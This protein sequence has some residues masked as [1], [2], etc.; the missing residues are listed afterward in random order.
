ML[1]QLYTPKP[2]PITF[3]MLTFIILYPFYYLTNVTST[4]ATTPTTSSLTLVV[5]SPLDATDTNPGDGVCRTT[6][7][8]SPCTLRAAIQESN[9]HPGHDTIILN[10]V[11]Y[12]LTLTGPNENRALTGDLDIYD[13]LTINGT[14][15]EQTIINAQGLDRIF[16]IFL[17]GQAPHN[18]TNDPSPNQLQKL[19]VNINN[20]T[21]SGGVSGS[22]GT[23]LINH[24]GHLT[25]NQTIITN[26]HE[27]NSASI[28]AADAPLTITHTIIENNSANLMTGYAL[29]TNGTTNLHRTIIRNNNA[30]AIRSFN[31]LTITQSSLTNNYRGLIN[32]ASAH[33]AQS[34]IGKN[35]NDGIFNLNQ[36]NI[37][38]STISQNDGVG[39]FNANPD[40]QIDITSSTIAYNKN[41]GIYA[42][43]GHI[44]LTNTLLAHN[45]TNCEVNHNLTSHGHNLSHDTTCPLY[46][47]GDQPATDPQLATL[48]NNGGPTETNALLTGS[49][50]INLGFCAG[51]QQ[52][53]QR[54]ISRPLG[55]ACDIGAY[56]YNGAFF[57]NARDDNYLLTQNQPFTPPD[58]ILTNDNY[59][60]SIPF[61]ITVLT[62]THVGTLDLAA[63]GLFTYTPPLNFVG[64]TSFVYQLRGP[65]HQD[66]ATVTLTIEPPQCWTSLNAQTTYRASADAT[67]LQATINAAPPNTIIYLAG[68]C[69][70]TRHDTNYY[71]TTTI[72]KSIT[73]Q[74]GYTHTNWSNHN[75]TL[76]TTTLSAAGRGRVLHIAPNHNV[77]LNHLTLTNGFAPLG[78]PGAAIYN[79]GHLTLNQIH[80]HNNTATAPGA[81]IYATNGS[82]TINNSRISYN[83]SDIDSQ[84]ILYITTPW[85][86][87][88]SHLEQNQGGTLL[89][90]N[91]PAT[92]LN[93]QFIANGQFVNQSQLPLQLRLTNFTQTSLHNEGHL[94][95]QKL[96]LTQNEI[97]AILNSG[98]L[99]LTHSLIYNNPGGILNN[100]QLRLE[101]STIS[102]NSNYGLFQAATGQTK[103]QNVTLAA[104]RINIDQDQTSTNPLQIILLNTLIANPTPNGQNCYVQ[105]LASLGHNLTTDDT[106]P[107]SAPSD[108]TNTPLTLGP[109]QDNGGNTLTHALA[110]H[111]PAIGTAL[112]LNT[113]T[114]T[115]QRGTR[116]PQGNLCDIGAFEYVGT[117]FIN[118]SDDAFLAP[119][120][121]TFTLPPPGLWL[122]KPHY[123]DNPQLTIHQPPNS[124]NLNLNHDGSFTYTPTNNPP[125][126]ISF[127]YEINTTPITTATVTL[128]LQPVQ[129][130][131][132]PDDGQTIFASPDHNALYQALNQNPNATIKVAG[133][134]RGTTYHLLAPQTI[135]PTPHLTIQGGYTLTNWLAPQTDRFPT[136]LDA[137]DN[138]RLLT[139][140]DDTSATL[141]HLT[142]R[143]GRP[144]DTFGAAIYAHNAQL[145]LDHV[146]IEDNTANQTYNASLHLENSQ[147]HIN[148][149]RLQHNQGSGLITINNNL[150]LTRTRIT[151]HTGVGLIQLPAS[152]DTAAVFLHNVHI[153]HN[154]IDGINNQHIITATHI[155]LAHNGGVG[156]RNTTGNS[157]LNLYRAN[158]HHNQNGGLNNRDGHID[159]YH[160]AIHSNGGNG[161][162]HCRTTADHSQMN[163]INSTI[164]QHNQNIGV[165]VCPNQN[166]LTLNLY[167][168]TIAHNNGGGLYAND[169]THLYN[170]LIANNQN[171]DC[172]ATQAPTSHGHNLDS[173]DT[174]HLGHPTDL[175]ATNPLLNTLDDNQDPAN[176]NDPT[177]TH[178][179]LPGSPAINHVPFG[180][181]GCLDTI[182]TDQRGAS[183][184]SGGACDI[185]AYE[186]APVLTAHN[187][188]VAEE[189][190]PVIFHIPVNLLGRFTTPQTITYTTSSGT[191][192]PHLDYEPITGTLHFPANSDNHTLTIPLTILPDAIPESRETLYINLHA[193][194][195]A[196]LLTP[197]LRLTIIDPTTMPHHL[198]LPIIIKQ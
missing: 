185:G 179:L 37:D 81:A 17:A 139:L 78:H 88:D 80:L 146:I 52:V 164:S 188:M 23:A 144:N 97:N 65:V 157:R 58:T 189:S 171:G 35:Q 70:G 177:L 86:M 16:D 106:C 21:I 83:Q 107:L 167:H 29:D 98:H 112:C 41:K 135:P 111:A 141:S 51:H 108:Q 91:A 182:P 136:I 103:L 26:N 12:N 133:H 176:L 181:N 42:I 68:T 53:D 24:H 96:T 30:T 61:N 132:T 36:I 172:H 31:H 196:S 90:T 9:A 162:Y 150:Y 102:Q 195:S 33:I 161:L 47:Y 77:T 127:I 154:Q 6:L 25:L 151:D 87:V 174:C 131:A 64:Q 5:T 11:T 22:S 27:T 158:I 99:T 198:N 101:D 75:P 7:N 15:R 49:P 184:A 89:F 109:L 100:G 194:P 8:N 117:P 118:I 147:V 116:R 153:S 160:A 73:L 186:V 168:S 123:L 60:V 149:S 1:K 71:Q 10:A 197:Q 193:P 76:F 85:Q 175:P 121:Q 20:L 191:A 59:I 155:T 40:S 178:A 140:T 93:S 137:G 187:A 192:R 55:L 113:P 163:V 120:D 67:A 39:L 69:L 92:I 183:R 190:T 180:T 13:N 34:L 170:S 166:M 4:S 173:D 74:G 156:L 79:H 72:N 44:N 124:G 19:T 56:E 105:H 104:N 159:L 122:N 128:D 129:C 148:D 145:N 125:P 50:A 18:N 3:I 2:L 114:N 14:S 138:G 46:S 143:G 134:C 63:N 169:D 28:I 48:A 126:S 45:L 54:N 110:D 142:L 84:A 43:I 82:L 95:A 130:W 119:A 38:N 94:H 152:A 32:H 115:D 165:Y 57:I 66:T 62:T